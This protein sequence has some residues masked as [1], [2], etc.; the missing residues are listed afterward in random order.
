[1]RGKTPKKSMELTSN[2]DMKGHLMLKA[3]INTVKNEASSLQA[4]LLKSE[5]MSHNQ[6]VFYRVP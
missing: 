5:E 3:F 2:G 6:T 1:M 4:N